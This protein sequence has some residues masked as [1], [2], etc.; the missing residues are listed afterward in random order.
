MLGAGFANNNYALAKTCDRVYYHQSKLSVDWNRLVERNIMFIIAQ[1][2]FVDFRLLSSEKDKYNDC[3]FPNTF[4]KVTYKPIYY[5]FFGEEKNRYSP[6]Q[7]PL[8][9]RQFFN[10]HR[11]IHIN[12]QAFIGESFYHPTLLF[13]RLFEEAQFFHFDIGIREIFK[14]NF[15]RHDF[16]RFINEF[17]KSP[18]FE[19]NGKY[20]TTNKQ[21]TFIELVEQIKQMYLYATKSKQVEELND[22]FSQIVLGCPALFVTYDKNEIHS[23]GNAKEVKINNG[24]KVRYNMIS[25]KHSFVSV[26]FIGKD[27]IS[28]YDQELRNLRIYLSKLHVYKEATRLIL[29]KLKYNISNELDMHKVITFF[30]YMLSLIEREKYYGYNNTDFWK[31]VFDVDNTYNNV[32]WN[33]Y[34]RY[35]SAKIQ[36]V[37][38]MNPKS[39]TIIVT[40]STIEG[41]IITDSSNVQVNNEKQSKM[42]ENIKK[43]DDILDELLNSSQLTNQQIESLNDQINNF[44]EYIKNDS[45]Q[46]GFASKLLNSIKNTFNCM[47]SN[48][49]GIQKLIV[50]GESIINLL[51]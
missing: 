6:N 34:R 1:I 11:A 14:N 8:S 51:K 50:A 40:D 17:L 33:E 45:P 25:I 3:F 35:M 9:E 21:Y 48:S 26:W 10:A 20:D 43:F 4:N 38:N 16:N 24:I 32:S 12:S 27:G 30:E 5:R 22:N 15:K 46:K 42:E 31:I 49:D 7:L 29:D 37:A 28:K 44:K 47:I 23:F 13:S 2:P 39:N 41:S 19:V 18:F 36:E